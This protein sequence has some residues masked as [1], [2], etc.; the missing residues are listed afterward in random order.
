MNSLCISGKLPATSN[1]RSGALRLRN[2]TLVANTMRGMNSPIKVFGKVISVDASGIRAAGLSRLARRGDIVKFRSGEKA[3]IGEITSIDPEGVTVKP[4]SNEVAI[5]L[6]MA[7]EYVGEFTFQPSS[8]WLGRSIS[9]FAEPV[10]DLGVLQQGPNS[11]SIHN[12][13]PPATNRTIVK[14]AI[15]TG[16]RSVDIFTPLCFGQRIGI[17]AG[18]GVGKSTLLAMIAR[19]PGFDVAVIALV[20]E[21]GREVNEFIHEVLGETMKK[22]VL[23][24]A[25]GDEAPGMRKMAP[26]MA[27]RLAE[28]FR[29]EGKRVLLIM[30]S[31]TRYAMAA[32]EIALASGEAPVSRGYPP[33]VFSELPQL[34]ERAGPGIDGRG[35]ITG[36]YSVLVDGDN[37]NEPVSDAVRGILDG[38]IVLDREIANS[39]RFPAIDILASISRL[40]NKAWQPVNGKLAGDARQLIN[41]F[42]N[43]KD[44]RLLGSYQHGG[45]KELDHAIEVV[46]KIYNF[47]TQ[48]MNAKPDL[49][50]FASL[51]Q[52]IK[53]PRL[54]Q[55]AATSRPTS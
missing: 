29:D 23:V 40:A 37:H 34:L 13:P 44:L 6:D 17:F 8:T 14:D 28:H 2:F 1:S 52:L 50:S 27:T 47:L 55:A 54:S 39:G 18:S 42:E 35:S 25:T 31:V 36:V 16:V 26:L 41:R 21:R 20:G 5:Q 10:D 46:P 45:D 3:S 48:A 24:V 51:A 30:D 43:S 38:H 22:S 15:I 12:S 7:V 32:R 4:F 53:P 33:S 9:A 49:E 19:S 11:I